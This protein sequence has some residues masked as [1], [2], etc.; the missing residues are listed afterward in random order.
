MTMGVGA[1]VARWTGRDA[2][3]AAQL[4]AAALDTRYEHPHHDTTVG[5]R[6]PTETP[7]AMALANRN[8][9]ANHAIRAN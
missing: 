6:L 9:D 4:P 3:P 8:R 1:F 7:A 5:R 2:T